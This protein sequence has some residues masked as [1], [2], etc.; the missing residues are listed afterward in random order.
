[1]VAV[2]NAFA[3]PV[4]YQ[5]NLMVQGAGGYTFGDFLKFGLP[6]QVLTAIPAVLLA[7]FIFGGGS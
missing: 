4:G 2:S 6:L 3:S 1:M 7:Y 5:T